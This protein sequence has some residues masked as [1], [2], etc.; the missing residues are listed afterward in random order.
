[1][2]SQLLLCACAAALPSYGDYDYDTMEPATLVLEVAAERS[3]LMQWLDRA[4]PGVIFLETPA[5]ALPERIPDA[6]C[7]LCVSLVL[8]NAL[9]FGCLLTHCAR[10]RAEAAASPRVV[11]VSPKWVMDAA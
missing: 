2:L 10:A 8:M 11:H 1:M 5:A 7:C 9:L 3:Q 4:S 6:G